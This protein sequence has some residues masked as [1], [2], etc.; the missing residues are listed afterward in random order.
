MKVMYWVAG[1]GVVSSG[2][3]STFGIL[4]CSSEREAVWRGP[5]ALPRHSRQILRTRIFSVKHVERLGCTGVSLKKYKRY[6]TKQKRERER[7]RARGSIPNVNRAR[8]TL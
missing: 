2:I 6:M 1:R 3:H 5:G 8:L 4:L 7:E